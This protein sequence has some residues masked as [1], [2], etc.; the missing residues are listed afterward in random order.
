MSGTGAGGGGGGGGGGGCV[1]SVR[2]KARSKISR[3]NA[4]E[5][6]QPPVLVPARVPA[7]V[8]AEVEVV[9]GSLREVEEEEREER[10]TEHSV[11]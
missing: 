7:R 5:E 11:D 4:L 1:L 10:A 3:G 9:G 8:H 2:N 6:V